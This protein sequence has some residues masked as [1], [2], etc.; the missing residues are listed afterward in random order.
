MDCGVV[1]TDIVILAAGS[2]FQQM[3]SLVLFRVFRLLRLVRTQK[4]FRLFPRLFLM[5]KEL[6]HAFAAIFWGMT[7]TV[8]ILTLYSIMA[9]LFLNPINQELA[10]QGI[11]SG[12]ERCERAY[13]SVWQ[14]FLTF[15][16]QIIAGDSWGM[17]SVPIAERYPLAG[18][19]I[20]F[21]LVSVQLAVLNLI[22][23]ATVDSAAEARQGTQHELA[24]AKEELGEEAKVQL[25]RLCAQID[26]DQSGRLTL[27][28]LLEGLEHNQEWHDKITIMGVTQ[29]DMPI[30]FAIMDQDDS[31]DVD[32]Y[33]FVEELYKMR[34]QDS[35]TMLVFIKY[36]VTEI[37][38]KLQDQMM[39]LKKEI[40]AKLDAYE[41]DILQKITEEEEALREKNGSQ[42]ETIG[43]KDDDARQKLEGPSLL[44]RGGSVKALL[45]GKKSI[46]QASQDTLKMDE[47]MSRMDGMLQR[48]ET[49]DLEALSQVLG[50]QACSSEALDQGTNGK[51]PTFPGDLR[52]LQ[53]TRATSAPTHD[54]SM[55]PL[56]C[57]AGCVAPPIQRV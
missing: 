30:V 45:E 33:E 36:Y 18:M 1:G 40:V 24:L 57:V 48:I 42:R 12:C 2:I 16:Q 21:V 38:K 26:T 27:E 9:V 31:G 5:M 23:A 44:V 15:V 7:L 13:E 56:C 6:Q 54:R 10:K 39:I 11:Y 47:I 28:E 51:L 8:I 3:P 22:L 50:Q 34:S 53:F 41:A 32:Y 25:L 46:Y 37:R 19:F 55:R 43:A 49:L 29:D 52:Q 17:L 14:S 20:F 4:F 35:N